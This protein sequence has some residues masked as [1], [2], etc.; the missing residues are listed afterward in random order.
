MRKH[1]LKIDRSKMLDCKRG[2]HLGCMAV[3]TPV[4]LFKNTED[5]CYTTGRV[6][7]CDCHEVALLPYVE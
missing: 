4:G 2:N 6:C 1:P 3:V 5:E 7:T